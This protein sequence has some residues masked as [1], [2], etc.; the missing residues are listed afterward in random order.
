MPTPTLTELQQIYRDIDARYQ[1]W[2]RANQ[3]VNAWD[4]PAGSILASARDRAS[5]E[6]AKAERPR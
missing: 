1:D 4:D 6:L 3:G 2:K 5:N